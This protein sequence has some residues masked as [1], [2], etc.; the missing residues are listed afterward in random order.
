MANDFLI[1]FGVDST[2][3]FQGLNEIDGG[4]DD[5]TVN[6]TES[7]KLMQKAF[8]G[9][10][11]NSDKFNK[12]LA[13]GTKE[14]PKW[15]AIGNEAKGL[16][17][18]LADA[19]G[20]K[21]IGGD[22]EK[23]LNSF[24]GLMQKFTNQA[25]KKVSFN[26]DASK[27]AE[28][29][30]ILENGISDIKELNPVLDFAKQ[31][32]KELDPNSEEFAALSQQ[33]EIA[34][35]FLKEL[36]NTADQVV[37]KNKSLKTELKEIKAAMADMELA[38]QEDTKMFFDMAVRAGQLEDQIGDVSARV[39]VLASDTKY[40][41]AGIQAVTALTG[42][43]TAGQG[44]LALFGQENEDVQKA[45]Q[46]VT[47]AMALL[48][49]IQAVANALNKDS[50]LSVLLLG[51]AQK[52]RAVATTA[53]AAATTAETTATVGATVAARAW[54]AALLA[55]PI[56]LLV[57][58]IGAVVAALAAFTGGQSDAEKATNDLNEALERQG[59]LL[60]A[61]EAD[62]RRRT[63]L[64]V[65]R[66]KAAGKTESE[67]TTIEGKAVVERINLRRKNIDELT[68]LYNDEFNRKNR[69]AE[70]DKKLFDKI[71]QEREK[72]E[73]DENEAQIKLVERNKQRAD[74]QAD[75]LKKSLED[76]KKYAEE[77]KKILDQQVKFTT[78]LA[79]A[80]VSA[81]KNEFARERAEIRNQADEKIKELEREVVLS[82]EAGIKR[83]QLITQLRRNEAA[84]IEKI[85]KKEAEAKLALQ[86]QADSIVADLLEESAS[87]EIELTRLKFIEKRKDVEEQFKDDKE[88]RIRLIKELNQA[89]A[90]ELDK[91]S[92][93][94]ILDD[95]K[96]EEEQE[97]LLV[98]TA[99]QFQGRG[100]KVEE[101]KQIDILKVKLKYASITLQQL[102]DQ[103]NAENS[104]VVLQAKKAVQELTKALGIAVDE[105]KEK[106][107]QFSMFDIL[108]LGDLSDEQK[109]AVTRAAK[110]ALQSVSEITDF[111]IDQ[112]QRQIDKRQDVID[113]IEDSIDDLEE[114][115]DRE[116]ELREGGFAN[117]V[118]LLEKELEE[119]KKAKDEQVK[120]Q[121]DLQKK[122]QAL[123]KA[124]LVLDTAVQAQNLIT[125]ATSIFKSLAPIPFV[126]IPLAIGIIG[127][128]T[129]AFIAAKVKAFQLVNQ[130][131]QQFEKGGY[132]DGK[133]H[134]EGGKKYFAADG[135]GDVVE[136]EGGEH[137]TNKKSAKKYS[138]L[139][140]AINQDK[141]IGMSDQALR[142]ML[143][144]MGIQF[145]SDTGNDAVFNS[146]QRDEY[147]EKVVFLQ[148]QKEDT[149]LKEIREDVK[150]LANRK[151]EDPVFRE[152]DE[153]IYEKKGNQ[154]IRIKKK[155]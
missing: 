53:V 150:Y 28:F 135:S 20:G 79:D 90:D 52:G 140:D 84:E 15:V 106:Q 137:V 42:A 35:T 80:R 116:K 148:S 92:K 103:G 153:Y 40:L 46:K 134:S 11:Q 129:G 114:Q 99:A 123:Q 9:A 119:K 32:L 141:L 124:Q 128:M 122:Q 97:T 146:R 33:I 155:S 81:I 66:A 93:K 96:R 44:A 65:A 69:S 4:L 85:N 131:G 7:G 120:Q 2:K 143:A 55:N 39:R 139:L 23:K 67:I 78:E 49:G 149:D 56:F 10:A 76:Q 83:T 154:T 21:N 19:L 87:K 57:A 48:Q 25:G 88:T 100:A 73:D 16:G 68:N 14:W 138:N 51:N 30:K 62:L 63:A 151:R 107:G 74:E 37:T 125:S 43:F 126:G 8:E 27:L 117:S 6:V 95:L 5:L 17:K 127:L 34:D 113:Q 29:E 108:G 12:S 71:A 64:D 105:Q 61:D 118:E 58:V 109:E 147:R 45:I 102:I 26:I 60:E 133:P 130:G 70:D 142:E 47:G 13:N 94:R 41:D 3:F 72:Q 18:T 110:Q 1:P 152:D 59:I 136:L 91:A 38:G 132:I 24:T 115:L 77:Q 104:V 22:L 101:Q 31:K 36:G 112:Y 98:E 75:I 111:I 86:F 54:T 145:D 121:E 82:A 89:E 144:G 50:A